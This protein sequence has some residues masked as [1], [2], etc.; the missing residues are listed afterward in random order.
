MRLLK[1]QSETALRI[2]YHGDLRVVS[3][4]NDCRRWFFTINGNDCSSPATIDATVHPTGVTDL[5]NHRPGTLD[6][7]CE[8]ITKGRVIVGLSIGKCKYGYENNS[9]D[10]YTCW[11]SVCPVI[12]EEVPPLQ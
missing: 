2:T 10:G 8:N 1:T 6:G 9:G 11:G 3:S 12:I 5:N 7:F 4:S